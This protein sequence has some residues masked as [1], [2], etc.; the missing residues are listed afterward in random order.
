[1]TKFHEST[2]T[3]LSDLLFWNIRCW[4][5]QDK[6]NEGARLEDL[7][8]QG[9]LRY[10]KGLKSI[11]E[12]RWNKSKPKAEAAKTGLS[13]LDTGVSGFLRTD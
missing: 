9:V 13:S 1:M 8:I 11:K 12:P 7:K 5:F 6:T 4:Q 2:K 3:G 10:G